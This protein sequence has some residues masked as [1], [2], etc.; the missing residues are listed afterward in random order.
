MLGAGYVNWLDWVFL[1]LLVVGAFAGWRAGL[2]WAAVYFVS[3]FIAGFFAARLGGATS[4]GVDAYTDSP[5]LLSLLDS[6]LYLLILTLLLYVASR[7]LRALKPVLSTATFGLSSV[8]DRVG[9]LVVG[10]IVALLVIAAVVLVMARLTYQLD[11][12]AVEVDVPGPVSERLQT[13]EKVVVDLQ[14]ILT[15]SQVVG[16]AVPVAV[17]LPGDVLG[18]APTTFGTSL[19]L[20]DAAL[21]VADGDAALD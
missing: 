16:V 19:L 3:V 12:R 5:F 2:F 17:A 7:L 14:D 21:E 8:V 18:L 6:I 10:L 13:G 20:L 1:A 15:S 4:L 9:G 11:L